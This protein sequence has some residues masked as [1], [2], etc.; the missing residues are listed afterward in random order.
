[1]KKYAIVTDF[2]GTVTKLDIGNAISIHLGSTTQEQI[3]QDYIDNVDQKEW[4]KKQFGN[5]KMN[6]EE[7]ESLVLSYAE[8]KEGFEELAAY[9]KEHNIPFEIASGGLDLYINPVLKKT[10]TGHL[11]VYSAV[12]VYTENGILLDFP[13]SNNITLDDFKAS[14]VEL[15]KQQGYTV[16]FLGDGISDFKAAQKADIVFAVDY[17]EGLCKQ[18]NV[19]YYEFKNFN[20]ALKI[21]RDN[22]VPVPTHT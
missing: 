2:D 21:V 17:L 11:P 19:Q 20:T 9:S 22:H 10:N 1:M 3:E 4:M 13:Y 18:H 16:I 7:F 6:R 8:V 5:I 15:Y 14:R 12:G